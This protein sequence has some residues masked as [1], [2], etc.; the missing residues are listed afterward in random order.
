MNFDSH[1]YGDFSAK[2]NH[3]A[4]ARPSASWTWSSAYSCLDHG[5]TTAACAAQFRGLGVSVSTNQAL[6]QVIESKDQLIAVLTIELASHTQG[7][8]ERRAN[9]YRVYQGNKTDSSSADP[10]L[11]PVTFSRWTWLLLILIALCAAF[12]WAWLGGYLLGFTLRD[13]DLDFSTQEPFISA[14]THG[15][16]SSFVSGCAKPL[17][18]KR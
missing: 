15:G 16:M 1:R 6:L 12:A 8:R 5:T 3:S 4:K 10:E 7:T 9:S 13:S 18:V 17:L 14:M 11:K 2:F